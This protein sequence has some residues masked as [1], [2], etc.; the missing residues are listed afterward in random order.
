M[1][2]PSSSVRRFHNSMCNS[3]YF[4]GIC[5][6]HVRLLSKTLDRAASNINYQQGSINCNGLSTTR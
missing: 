3:N 5:T 1:V 4:S 6:P 2:C